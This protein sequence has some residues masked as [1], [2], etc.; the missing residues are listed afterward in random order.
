M[1][2]DGSDVTDALWEEQVGPATIRYKDG[3]RI[4][5]Y[6]NRAFYTLPE[7]YENGYLSD[8]DL[9]DI[10]NLQRRYYEYLYADPEA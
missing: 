3:N 4:Q 1:I 9:A 5:V 8:S 6:H 10:E 2:N 7:A